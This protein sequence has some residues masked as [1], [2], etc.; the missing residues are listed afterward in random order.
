[1]ESCSKD[2]LAGTAEEGGCVNGQDYYS[3]EPTLRLEPGSQPVA[4]S[5][6]SAGEISELED[7]FRESEETYNH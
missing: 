4:K 1:M 5:M 3:T 6:R 2:R 7:E